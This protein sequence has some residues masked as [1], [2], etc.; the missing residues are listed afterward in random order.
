MQQVIEIWEVQVQGKK[1]RCGY[2]LLLMLLVT[3]IVGAAIWL[4]PSVLLSRGDPNL[5]WNQ[6]R[7]LV[8]KGQAVE[9]PSEQQLNIDR[10]WWFGA[11]VRQEDA[12]R[13][14][15]I[16]LLGPD[17]RIKGGWSGEYRPTA[18]LHYQVMAGNFKGNIDPSRI[19]SDEKGQD[20]SQLFFIAKGIFVILE[21]NSRTN[22]VRSVKGH[23]Y[24]TGWLDTEC[25]ATGK[26]TITSDKRTFKTFGWQ[27]QGNEQTHMLPFLK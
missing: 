15:I 11:T 17:G 7:R 23:I 20:E 22:R 21:T 4:G 8:R 2:V 6:A 13:G 18:E 27:G 5:P 1:S 10:L 14:E 16:M 9:G 12:E 3:M 26:V 25:K 24:V 19:Y